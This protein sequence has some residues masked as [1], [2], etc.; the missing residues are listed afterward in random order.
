V[1]VDDQGG[2]IS[3]YG[4]KR[5]AGTLDSCIGRKNDG[6]DDLS[7]HISLHGGKRCVGTWGGCIVV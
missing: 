3:L 2:Q 1:G 7:G 4:G 6:A 5:G